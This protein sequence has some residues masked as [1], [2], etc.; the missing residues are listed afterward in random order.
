M[1]EIVGAFLAV[2][3]QEEGANGVVDS[4]H[5]ALGEPAQIRFEYAERSLSW[6]HRARQRVGERDR[7][8]AARPCVTR[9]SLLFDPSSATSA[10]AKP[11]EALHREAPDDTRPQAP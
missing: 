7:L 3:G 10:T 2:E 11:G 8:R 9:R 6:L 5:G 1:A 4:R